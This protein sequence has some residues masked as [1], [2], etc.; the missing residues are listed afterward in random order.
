LVL[1]LILGIVYY[2]G[3]LVWAVL[4]LIIGVDH[5]PIMD[6]DVPLDIKRKVVGVIAFAVFIL[7]FIPI[8]VKFDF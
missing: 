4:I 2:P 7:T 3:W 6:D 8:P 1:L 5:P